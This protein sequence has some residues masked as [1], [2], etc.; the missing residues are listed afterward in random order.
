MSAVSQ[1]MRR[2]I[3]VFRINNPPVNA[4]SRTVLESLA[5]ALD[6]VERDPAVL[7]LVITGTPD[8]FAAG[9]DLP[10]FAREGIAPAEAIRRGVEVYGQMT[11]LP[12]PVVA[13]VTGYCLGGGMELAAA[14]DLR[15]A[16]PSARFGQP[17]VHLGIIPGWNGTVRLPRLL[18]QSHAAELILTGEPISAQRAY[19]IGFVHRLVDDALVV[20]TAVNLALQVASQGPRAVARAKQLLAAW[21]DPGAADREW[22]AMMDLLTS[23]E[24]MEGLTAFLERRRPRFREIG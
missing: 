2:G 12:K 18:G 10:S 1:D 11:R 5:A 16:G 17:E 13:A 7:G 24:A 22:E 8:A 14:S 23:P 15:V 6:E 9:A 3:R 20:D 19:A 21:T 4:L